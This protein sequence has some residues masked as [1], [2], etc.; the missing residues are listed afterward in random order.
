MRMPEQM[1]SLPPVAGGQIIFT[2]R[3]SA[4]RRVP[5]SDGRANQ[6][7][8][9]PASRPRTSSLYGRANP[10]HVAWTHPSKY[11][12]FSR[13]A[14]HRARAVEGRTSPGTVPYRTAPKRVRP[15]RNCT[16]ARR[17]LRHLTW[18]RLIQDVLPEAAP[19]PPTFGRARR[20]CHGSTRPAQNGLFPQ[21]FLDVPVEDGA[22]A[23][24]VVHA[25]PV[26]Q[27]DDPRPF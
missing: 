22:D 27:V 24:V 18:A 11:S 4:P 25:G 9:R 13:R 23:A 6:N 3:R 8:R 21:C 1:R 10:T 5:P 15:D 26:A 20:G 2:V 7:P 16:S 14:D 17:D 12:S 19:V